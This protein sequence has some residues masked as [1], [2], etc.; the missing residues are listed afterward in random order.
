[1]KKE[2]DYLF[3][4]IKG[5]LIFLVVLGHLLEYF[6]FKVTH[7]ID[8][9]YIGIYLFHMP[10]FVFIS[11]YF[12]KRNNKNRIIELTL[13][14]IIWQV[15][16]FPLLVSIFTE[17]SF[18]KNQQSVFLPEWTYWYL[19]SLIIW[20]VITPYFEKI[21]H[22]FITSLVLGALIGYS[23]L[24]SGLSVFS[25]GRTIA[26]YPFFILG[27]HCKKEHIYYF[28][29]KVNKYVGMIGFISIIFLGLILI[30]HVDNY[31]IKES[32]IKKIL[33]LK[34]PYEKY[35][36]NENMGALIRIVM[37]GIQ[38]LS[39]PLLFSFISDKQNI[40]SKFGQNTLFIYLTH[41]IVIQILK[42]TLLKKIVITNGMFILI[43]CIIVAFAYCLLL[44][45]N[46]IQ[47]LGKQITSIN[48]DMI[49]KSEK[50]HVVENKI[51]DVVK[52]I[53]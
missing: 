4:N 10:V 6:L 2:R 46:P 50:D 12:S 49:L 24:K 44:S 41:G 15:I 45:L 35:I 25:L 31:L 32:Y 7:S 42:N 9:M 5:L 13:V 28:K 14:Y 38:F 8:I 47:N 19:L 17:T 3:D 52:N 33:Y 37:Y 34:D 26:F 1:M 36:V 20:K 29:N 11:G 16:V 22:S 30:N 43:S 48:M 18:E 23:S 27:Y 53:S 21:R 40:L 39:I 51:E